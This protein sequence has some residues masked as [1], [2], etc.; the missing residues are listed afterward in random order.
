MSN[1]EGIVLCDDGEDAVLHVS[2][3][4]DNSRSA[5]MNIARALVEGSGE[6]GGGLGLLE[7]SGVFATMLESRTEPVCIKDGK[8]RWLVAN[9]AMLEMLDLVGVD[10]VGRTNG[11]LARN[12]PRVSGIV[13]DMDRTDDL[14]WKFR[15][16]LGYEL[17][18]NNSREDRWRAEGTKL[19]VFNTSGERCLLIDMG[20]RYIY[21]QSSCASYEQVQARG[22]AILSLMR[23]IDHLSTRL[24]TTSSL[25][26]IFREIIPVFS[27]TFGFTS[28]KL[29]TFSESF[30]SVSTVKEPVSGFTCVAPAEFKLLPREVRSLLW[31][32]DRNLMGPCVR[33]CPNYDTLLRLCE[34]HEARSLVAIPL[35]CHGE[36]DGL[37]CMWTSAP[38]VLSGK[39]RRVL[40]L[41]VEFLTSACERIMNLHVKRA[42]AGIRMILDRSLDYAS[43]GNMS[44]SI[45]HDIKQPL[46]AL[47]LN[48]DRMIFLRELNRDIPIEEI[49][50]NLGFIVEQADRID[51]YINIIGD[52]SGCLENNPR[53]VFS[54]NSTV[55]QLLDYAH[56][57][58]E[59]HDV[60]IDVRYDT[61][62]PLINADC[63]ALRRIL[64]NMLIHY[65]KVIRE[66]GNEKKAIHLSTFNE[67]TMCGITIGCNASHNI[68]SCSESGCDEIDITGDA[69][70][71]LIIADK[72]AREM[73]G[74]VQVMPQPGMARRYRIQMPCHTDPER[75]L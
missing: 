23:I 31:G 72:L 3:D 54:L 15:E 37:L 30:F 13:H 61:G 19:P 74:A 60:M 14:A 27:A 73:N 75:T 7:H 18:I 63:S 39:R 55:R 52:L 45:A 17:P 4:S 5:C 47:R 56:P 2:N 70:L 1:R 48:V 34:L 46:T 59:K 38:V 32:V 68:C 40:S 16:P 71:E 64:F 9:R 6:T 50:E 28:C 25:S 66:C 41:A 35:A 43:A 53:R 62:D 44:A 20:V 57:Y 26:D 12:N 42:A 58:F 22:E 33:D 29:Y 67:D 65:I 8:S 69:P 11:Q 24:R 51:S 49:Y 21:D 10:Y 36:V